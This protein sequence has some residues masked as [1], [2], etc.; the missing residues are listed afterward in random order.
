MLIDKKI[1]RS[2]F[3]YNLSVNGNG[4]N[5]KMKKLSNMRIVNLMAKKK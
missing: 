5:F 4:V 1:D 3:M 2:R